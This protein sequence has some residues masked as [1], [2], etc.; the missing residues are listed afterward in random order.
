[1]AETLDTKPVLHATAGDNV[2]SGDGAVAPL[3]ED[4]KRIERKLVRKIDLLILP[5]VALAFFLSVIDRGNYGFARLQ[6]LE[7]DLHM[8]G[9]E[10]Q[11]ALSIFYVGYMLFG[12]PSNMLL[13]YF[14]RPSWHIGLA[15]VAW[16]TVTACT[17]A[18]NNFGG[19]M[20]CRTLLGVVEAP[21]YAGMLFYL[22]KWY[23]KTELSL[24]I[25]LC[26]SFGLMAAATGPL[27]AAGVLSG[28]DGAKGL[29]AWRWL[30]IIEGTAIRRLTLDASE[31]DIDEAGISAM[32][33]VK[34][35]LRDPKLYLLCFMQLCIIVGIG[36][37]AFYPT[38]TATLGYSH[39]ISL[40]LVAPP[41]FFTAI[42]C[43][44]HSHLSDRTGRRFWYMIYPAPLAVAGYAIYMSPVSSFG[45][46]YVALFLML[47]VY[48]MN[49]TANAWLATTI[50]RP[51]AKRAAAYGFLTVVPHTSSIW[52]SFTYRNNDSPY[53][54][55]AL[56]IAAGMITLAAASAVWLRVL[57]VRENRR[58]EEEEKR[59]LDLAG[60]RSGADVAPGQEGSSFRYTI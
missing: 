37:Q 39:V 54:R 34:L 13:N 4:E 58:L 56:G 40:L 22:S 8:S 43:C 12:V 47:S 42:H 26:L 60:S 57:L 59:K 36:S 2:R 24:R 6:H 49:M 48:S 45:A 1:M 30:Y 21:V 33:G 17:A 5:M 3:S 52:S 25:S 15:V 28:L 44:I 51:P 20:A 53:F 10:F 55:L 38:M 41:Y 23:K 18:V 19:M 35:A 14:G 31:A 50:S 9:S 29:S 16:G 7:R 32:D 46:R 11:A 27:I